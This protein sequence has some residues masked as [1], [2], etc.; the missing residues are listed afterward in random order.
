MPT[1]TLSAPVTPEET[2]D[3]V[4]FFYGD[5]DYDDNYCEG[6]PEFRTGTLEQ[7][8]ADNEGYSDAG[9]ATVMTLKDWEK[10]EFQKEAEHMEVVMANI[11]REHK[12]ST[13]FC[14]EFIAILLKKINAIQSDYDSQL[15]GM[16]E[17]GLCAG[18]GITP[19]QYFNDRDFVIGRRE[20]DVSEYDILNAMERHFPLRYAKAMEEYMALPREESDEDED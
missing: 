8:E 9:T 14:G 13:A 6:G 5:Y 1:A 18:W 2:I 20:R 15:Q 19:E 17:D 12:L 3:Y 11:I 7:F 4:V 10:Q 16:E